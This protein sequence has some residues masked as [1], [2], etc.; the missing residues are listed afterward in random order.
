[1]KIR[2]DC[3]KGKIRENSGW[4]QVHKW[5]I[6]DLGRIPVWR[7]GISGKT[8]VWEQEHYLIQ[9]DSVRIPAWERENFRL[10]MG[11]IFPSR[12]SLVSDIPA[13]EGNTAKPFFTVYGVAA[14]STDNNRIG[15]PEIYGK[16]GKQWEKKTVLKWAQNEM[17]KTMIILE[18]PVENKLR[19][20]LL[21]TLIRKLA[22]SALHW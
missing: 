22:V 7:G 13:G 12:K 14:R 9:K 2:E 4:E 6:K 20:I 16:V 11:N 10:N 15:I 19:A 5:V 1:M 8:P 21:M 3:P 18:F 17:N